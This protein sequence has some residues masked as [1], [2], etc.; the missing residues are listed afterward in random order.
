[1]NYQ[2]NYI[3]LSEYKRITILN[4]K[5]VKTSDDLIKMSKSD[6][7]IYVLDDDKI[8]AV[9]NRYGQSAKTYRADRTLIAKALLAQEDT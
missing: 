2:V 1:M 4:D 8:Y 9:K 3:D 5:R 6:L 7:A